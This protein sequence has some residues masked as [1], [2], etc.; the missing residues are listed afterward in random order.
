M[1]PVS[2]TGIEIN[3]IGDIPATS[4]RRHFGRKEASPHDN[5]ALSAACLLHLVLVLVD[6][7]LHLLQL[8]VLR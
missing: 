2:T 3:K 1:V 4:I 6:L 7:A 8:L 5:T